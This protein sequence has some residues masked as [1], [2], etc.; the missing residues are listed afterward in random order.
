MGQVY[1]AHDTKLNRDVALKVLPD[2]LAN[3]PARFARFT[4][5][6]QT[7]AALNHPN[8]AQVHGLEESSIAGSGHGLIRALVME[9]VEGED[10]SERI[11]RGAIPIDEAFP[12]AKQIAEAL[13]AAHELG[14]VHRDLKPANV[15]VRSDG[16]VKVLDF[17]LAK[18]LAPFAQTPGAGP[19]ALGVPGHESPTIT[20]PAHLRQDYGGQAMT[21][22]GMIVGTAAYM[23][24]EQAKGRPVDKRSDVWAFG[25]VLYEM[26]TGLRAFKGEDTTDTITAVVS[27]EP[28]WTALPTRT[29]PAIHKLLRRC[30]EKDR[31]RRLD[32][33][34][35]A[36]LELEDA[37]GSSSVFEGTVTTSTTSPSRGSV[38]RLIAATAVLAAA[39]LAVPAVRHLGETPQPPPPETRVDIVTPGADQAASFALSPDGRQI[40]FVAADTGASRLWLRSLATTTTQPL[41]GTE[42]ARY[43]FWSPD[44]RSIGFFAANTL[45]RLDVVPSGGGVPRT[46]APAVDGQGGTW[47]ADGVIAYAPGMNTTPLMRVAATGGA[48]TAVT[49]LGPQ[50]QGHVAPHFLPD[51]RRLL[52]YARGEPDTA[53]IYLV[54]LD[55]SALT[56]LTP[57]DSAGVFLPARSG[58]AAAVRERGPWSTEALGEDGWLL[59]TRAGTLVAQQLDG[60]K[61]VL[62]GKPVALAD[63]V[64]VDGF[65]WSAVSVAATGLVAY[66]T[67]TAPRRQLT[68]VERSGTVRGTLG[69]SEGTL[70]SPRVSPDGRHVAVGRTVQG[71]DDLWLLDG[72][73]TSR[74]TFDAA[75]DMY[76]VWSP[77]GGRLAFISM[78]TGA[79]DLYEKLV[80][81]AGVEERIVA[82]D[83]IKIPS[84]WSADGRFLLYHS[85]TAQ[86]VQADFDLW[87]VPMDRDRTPSVFLKTPF[88]ERWGALSPDGRWVAYHSNESG[89]MEAYVRPFIPPSPSTSAAKPGGQ[90]QVSTAGGIHPVWRPDGKELYYLNP[91][92]AMM[93]API[94]VTGATLEP[95]V[96]AVLFA[97]RIF[98]GAWTVNKVASTTSPQ[99]GA[100]SSTQCWKTRRHRLLS[101]RTGRVGFQPAKSNE[102]HSDGSAVST[103]ASRDDEM[104]PA[105]RRRILPCRTQ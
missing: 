16:T 65:I 12:I 82:S 97:T 9:L 66:R 68:W 69:D 32:S 85:A 77:D 20:S 64:A 37:M 53:G 81:G 80:N 13:A 42:G 102:T 31:K 84:S 18:G 8:I 41:A 101:S 86:Q 33:A 63:G 15:R 76:P 47:N 75:L 26:L 88:N 92:G 40:V 14:I 57:S 73:R 35:D 44:G 10:L 98:G 58:L 96:P 50:Q 1:R 27:K 67:G 79:F 59:W 60:A 93:A 74:V 95:G 19:E 46:L 6:A 36:R 89:R 25:A 90:R 56:R 3:D 71:N 5:E 52:F 99:T 21:Q 22:A 78:R 2:S 103:L 91:A 39:A 38:P 61:A 54:A 24:P 43:P 62:T 83:Q 51:G 87:V 7:L 29:P 49:A 105:R 30:L 94:T 48:T 70:S 45:K 23:S 28:D 100:S 55:G 104:K 11:A 34:G 72:D 4:R 17:G